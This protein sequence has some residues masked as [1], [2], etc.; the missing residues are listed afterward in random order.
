[1]TFPRIFI[2]EMTDI[3]LNSVSSVSSDDFDGGHK[4]ASI[5]VFYGD[6]IRNIMAQRFLEDRENKCPSTSYAVTCNPVALLF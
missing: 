3:E 5:D 4:V 2:E 1:M 6:H